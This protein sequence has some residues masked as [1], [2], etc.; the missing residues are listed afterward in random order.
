L[1][2]QGIEPGDQ[3]KDYRITS[4]IN[5]GGTAVVYSAEH[6]RIGRK[7]AVKVLRPQL[8]QDEQLVRRFLREARVVNRVNH[9]NIVEV[10]DLIEQTDRDPPLIGMV[11][12]VLRGQDLSERL[13]TQ[14][15]LN[16]KEAVV[17]A[18]Q[19][20]DA[21]NALHQAQILHRD[22]KP[23]NIFLLKHPGREISVKL[24]DLG[25][26]KVLGG[27][28][29]TMLTAAGTGVGTPLYMAPEQVLGRELDART[30]IYGLGTTLGGRAGRRSLPVSKP[31]SCAA[32]RRNRKGAS[33]APRGCTRRCSLA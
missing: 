7:V 23:E 25:I 12:E 9:P 30:D 4:V 26:A 16:M 29:G 27:P 2:E 20:A 22:I 11:M 13:N 32:W 3:L 14:R 8:A 17:I 15:V 33:R 19:V 10:Y 1:S 21:L 28:D 5:D 6:V 18:A 31:W 24:L